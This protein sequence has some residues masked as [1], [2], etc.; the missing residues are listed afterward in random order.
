[1][2]RRNEYIQHV[3]ADLVGVI[4]YADGPKPVVPLTSIQN[5]SALNA[6]G[7]LLPYGM[8]NLTS[9]LGLAQDWLTAQSREIVRRVVVIGDGEPNVDTDRL[10]PTVSAMRDQYITIDSV[11]CGEHGSSG[12][13][14]LARIS[15]ATVGGKAY[16]ARDV[17]ALKELVIKNAARLHRRQAAT[18]F[19]LD[20][21][22]SMATP[23]SGGSS[24]RMQAAIQAYQSFVL[25]KRVAYGEIGSR[26]RDVRPFR[27]HRLKIGV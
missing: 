25:V 26:N 15:A 1:M 9:G 11:F 10:Y 13:Q 17:E 19:L 12:E 8:T 20:C 2:N 24:S 16:T 3:S 27:Q 23:M 21:S 18:V 5:P 22:T 6:A 7:G 14:T 4:G